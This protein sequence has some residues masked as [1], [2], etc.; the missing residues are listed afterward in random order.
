[1]IL[2]KKGKLKVGKYR[3]G[4]IRGLRCYR[5]KEI[6]KYR[7]IKIFSRIGKCRKG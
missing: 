6:G 7:E 4:E 5:E 1:M 3:G 2:L